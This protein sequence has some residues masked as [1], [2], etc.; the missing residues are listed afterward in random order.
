MNKNNT[1]PYLGSQSPPTSFFDPDIQQYCDIVIDQYKHQP[2]VP[3]DWPPHVGE[4]FFGRL[5]LLHRLDR[6]CTSQI[7]LQCH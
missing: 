2:I 1:Y 7:A 3:T 4:D 5:V 6:Y